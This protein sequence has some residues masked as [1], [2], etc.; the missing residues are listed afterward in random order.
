M[1]WSNDSAVTWEAQEDLAMDLDEFA[2]L[3]SD[4]ESASQSEGMEVGAN[5]GAGAV[6]YSE[7]T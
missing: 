5:I 2:G 4:M 7:T 6:L 3:V 1:E